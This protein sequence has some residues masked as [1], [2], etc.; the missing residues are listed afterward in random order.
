LAGSSRGVDDSERP[1]NAPNDDGSLQIYDDTENGAPTPG[2]DT[3]TTRWKNLGGYHDV[4]KENTAKAT[5]WTGQRATQSKRKVTV[6]TDEIDVYE[7][8]EC[9]KASD[10]KAATT[11]VANKGSLRQRA[12]RVADLSRNPMLYHGSGAPKPPSGRVERAKTLYRGF[13]PAHLR[14]ED[15]E[16]VCYEEIRAAAW[17]RANGPTHPPPKPTREPIIPRDASADVDMDVNMDVDDES[18][19][20]QAATRATEDRATSLADSR[21]KGK[22]DV[23]EIV[24]KRTYAAPPPPVGSRTGSCASEPSEG[25]S[26]RGARSHPR[27][28]DRRFQKVARSAIRR[29]KKF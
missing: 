23:A 15:G 4:R 27:P 9:L 10:V 25:Q 26:V 22:R 29:P 6:P 24:S 7:D 1:S 2:D 11:A 18:D 19:A 17:L 28:S 21:S 16:E 3:T 13:K 14:S 20:P 12:D 8:T 5:T